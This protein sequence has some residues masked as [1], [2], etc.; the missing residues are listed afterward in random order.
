MFRQVAPQVVMKNTK[1]KNVVNSA[2]TKMRE[3]S[4]IRLWQTI[5]NESQ[6][7]PHDNPAKPCDDQ[8]RLLK[9]IS[10]ELNSAAKNEGKRTEPK[11][12]YEGA[13]IPSR[14]FRQLQSEYSHSKSEPTFESPIHYESD[15]NT[16]KPKLSAGLLRLLQS[17]YNKLQNDRSP[18]DV[19][20]NSVVSSSFGEMNEYYNNGMMNT[21]ATK[22]SVL[23]ELTT[24]FDPVTQRRKPRAAPGR[25]FRYLQ[26]QYD[27]RNETCNESLNI[28]KTNGNN[29]NYSNCRNGLTNGNTTPTFNSPTFVYLQSQYNDNLENNSSLSKLPSVGQ[30]SEEHLNSLRI[31]E[32]V[33][34]V[35]SKPYLGNRIPGRTFKMLQENYATH[36]S[37]LQARK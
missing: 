15:G 33:E 35:H 31:T 20:N 4:P 1:H 21:A 16:D 11:I 13:K 36:P 37:V 12:L 18:S 5:P 2:L 3:P 30:A 27:D 10:P 26:E 19:E 32:E 25:V 14:A 7:G 23:K 17:D 34:P 8:S 6:V 24:Q 9:F 29:R 22:E 28:L